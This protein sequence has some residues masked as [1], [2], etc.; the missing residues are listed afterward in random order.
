MR[1]RISF[2]ALVASVLMGVLLG[3]CSGRQKTGQKAA[4]DSSATAFDSIV[5]DTTVA[6]EPSDAASPKA[7]VQLCLLYAKGADAQSLNDSILASG[8]LESDGVTANYAGKSP[9]ESVKAFLDAYFAQY[10]KDCSERYKGNKSVPAN[11]YEFISKGR[12]ADNGNYVTLVFDTYDF[13]GG[14]NGVSRQVVKNIDRRT[15]KMVARKDLFAKVPESKV[16][17]LIVEDFCRQFH[18]KD[19]K[20]LGD[21]PGIFFGMKPYVAR[22]FMMGRDS[23]TFVYGSDEIAPHAMGVVKAH[24]ALRDLGL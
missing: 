19:L 13:K 1:K 15:G 8:V 6:L 5:T 17:D 11:S 12:L 24:V 7:H 9:Q 2:G 23:V 22:D 18:A 4:P 16:A 20:A 14:A 10:R 21:T 3:A